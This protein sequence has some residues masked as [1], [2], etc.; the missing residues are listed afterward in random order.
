MELLLAA[1]LLFAPQPSIVVLGDSVARGA[2]D[3]SGR[4]ISGT[5]GAVNLGISPL[6]RF[7]PSAAGYRA[8]AERVRT[9]IGDARDRPP[10]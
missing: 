7:H 2:G 8:V 1:L 10:R 6:D 5:L 3:E 9:S 4:G